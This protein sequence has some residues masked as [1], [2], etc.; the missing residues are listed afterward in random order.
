MIKNILFDFDGVIADSV[1]VKTEAFYNMYLPYGKEIAEK[2]KEHHLNNGGMS[3]F[4]K[5]LHYHKT[6][7]NEDIND[8]QISQLA[9]DFSHL[10]LDGV[11]NS[12]LV[13]GILAFLK[14]NYKRKKFWIIT[15]TPTDEIK[16]ILDRKNLTKYFIDSF[17]SPQLKSAWTK[18]VLKDNQL[19]NDET[20]FIGDALA[21]YE[22]AVS[23]NIGFIL[24]L[25]EENINLFSTKNNILLK[26]NDFI[27]F[28]QNLELL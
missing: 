3:R 26:I 24:R 21:D 23:N 28:E 14:A 19:N 4:H 13:P 7:L 12:P 1:N 20:V 15:G 27:N 6:Y 17:G 2:V 10:V 9:N 5:F 25:T 16:I 18:L 8:S 22:A 11:V